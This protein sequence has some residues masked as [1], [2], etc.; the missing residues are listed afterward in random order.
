MTIVSVLEYNTFFRGLKITN[1]RLSS[2][3]LDRILHV[4]KRSMWL[5]E[6]H[7]EGV[8]IKADF[9]HKLAVALNSNTSSS[10]KTLSFSHNL[11]EDKGA[12]HLAG[13][14][15]KLS[16]GLFKLS[17]SHCSLTGKGINQIAHSLSIN[18]CT[19]TTLTFLDLSG[20]SLK[21]DINVKHI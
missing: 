16:K 19:S 17:L 2:E 3:T 8:T 20:N 14:I 1:S 5:E 11:I 9:L 4:L 18:Q 13:P 21:D 10:L 12:T 6:L 7:L 15:G